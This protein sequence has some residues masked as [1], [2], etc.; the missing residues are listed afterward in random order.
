MAPTR[1]FTL[2]PAHPPQLSDAQR[3]RLDAMTDAEITTA[4]DADPD[5]PSPTEPILDWIEAAA[6]IRR[7]RTAQGLTQAAFAD[8]YGFPAATLRDWE[9]G[10]RRPDRATLAYLRVIEHEPEAVRRALGT[11]AQ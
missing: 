9:Q 3:R 4:A 6:R 8:L 7:I 10:R 5:T 11:A 2:D 1:R